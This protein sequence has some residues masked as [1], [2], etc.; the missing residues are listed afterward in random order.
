MTVGNIVV[1]ASFGNIEPLNTLENEPAS[2]FAPHRSF[3]L[4]SDSAT[5]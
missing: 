1:G 2:K 3:H 4:P 5:A